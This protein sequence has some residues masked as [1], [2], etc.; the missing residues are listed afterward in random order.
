MNKIKIFINILTKL[1]PHFLFALLFSSV[2]LILK[3]QN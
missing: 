2:S 3:L 1:F